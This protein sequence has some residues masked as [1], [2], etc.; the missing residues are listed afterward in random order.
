MPQEDLMHEFLKDYKRLV[1]YNHL[2][3]ISENKPLPAKI[4]KDLWFRNLLSKHKIK[5]HKVP[6]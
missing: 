1:K 5:K 6:N 4:Q 3:I 2:H